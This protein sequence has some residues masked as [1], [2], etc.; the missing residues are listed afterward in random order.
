[1]SIKKVTV[2]GGGVLGSQIAFQSAYCG[3]E[4]TIF[5]RSLASKERTLA[6]VERLKNIY[7]ADLEATKGQLDKENPIYSH[8]LI[9][10]F[11]SLTIDEIDKLKERV[12][13]AFNNLKYQTSLKDAVIDADLVIEAVAENVD[14]KKE[15]YQ[16]MAPFLPSH[17]ILVTNS[18]TLLPSQFAASTLRP[19]KFLALHFANNIWRRNVT[20][21]MGHQGTDKKYYDEVVDF[22]KNINMIPLSLHK[23]QPGYLLN[24]LLVPFLVAAEKLL[25]E[26]VADVPTI[27]LAWRLGSGAPYGPFQIID[28]VGLTTAYNVAKMHP[29][30]TKENSSAA[31]IVALL[32][33]YI[34][35]GKTGVIAGEGFYKYR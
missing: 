29:E 26:E 30:A 9:K 28:I 33:K 35:E 22:A 31:K 18:S 21:I 20:E 4:V 1:M 27:D 5:A 11:N 12:I 10:D 7:L 24:S 32:K 25:V 6:K 19:D 14:E 17:T 13:L 16:Q 3:F 34:D 15:F 23:E 2:A 8:G